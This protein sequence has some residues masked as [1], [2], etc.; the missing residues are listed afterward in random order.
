MIIQ[1]EKVNNIRKRFS[2]KSLPVSHGMNCGFTFLELIISI[3]IIGVLVVVIISSLGA[4]RSAQSLT[5]SS[6]FVLG[7]LAEARSQTLGSVGD[8]Q[9][10]VYLESNQVTLFTGSSY[11]SSDPNNEEF[12]LESGVEIAD[13]TIGGGSSIVFE[14]LTGETNQ[15]GTFVVRLVGNTS[16][17]R[18]ISISPLGSISVE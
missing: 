18:T 17:F 12:S 13:I 16:K 4:Y 14:R 10:G 8:E 2:L 7:V 11:S 1:K 9:Y 5:Q 3:A 6:E 15:D